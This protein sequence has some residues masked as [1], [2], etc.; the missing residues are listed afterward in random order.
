ML[1]LQLQELASLSVV[2][3][4]G[5]CL[6]GSRREGEV[7]RSEQLTFSGQCEIAATCNER[8]FIDMWYN[9]GLG[10]PCS[11]ALFVRNSIRKPS[12]QLMR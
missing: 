9:Q 10:S 3:R 7:S 8:F 11:Y 12:L 6:V 1:G 4:V 2:T 5:G